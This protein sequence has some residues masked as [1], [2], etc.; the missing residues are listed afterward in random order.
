MTPT[1]EQL[2][3]CPEA[4]RAKY[5][6]NPDRYAA[7]IISTARQRAGLPPLHQQVGNFVK[8]AAE[9]V[10]SGLATVS[11]EEA[12]R[13]LAVCDGCEHHIAESNRCRLCGCGLSLKATWATQHC[14]D[15]RW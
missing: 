14:P 9:H 4:L 10:V 12:S 13:R 15:G 3:A 6:E 5:R 8:A 2:D 7:A 1:Q 11:P